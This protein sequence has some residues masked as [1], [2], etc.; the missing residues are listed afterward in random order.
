MLFR[1]LDVN[2]DWEFGAGKESFSSRDRA[3][4]LDIRTR[5]LSWVGDCF[6][7]S[8]AGIDWINRLGNKGQEV[9]LK[10]DLRRIIIQTEGVTRVEEVETKIVDR[11]FSAQY[12][13][14]TI[15]G[16]QFSN[17]VTLDI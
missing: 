8:D 7:D 11:T 3:I 6:F 14:S 16:N 12:T 2:G 17:S 15:Y 4:A 10:L 9:L 13:V 5:L 1:N